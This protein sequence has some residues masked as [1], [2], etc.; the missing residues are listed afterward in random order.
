MDNLRVVISVHVDHEDQLL[1][2]FSEAPH[3][4][5][6][7]FLV[8]EYLFHMCCLQALFEVMLWVKRPP[9]FLNRRLLYG[10]LQGC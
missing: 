3:N 1:A 4:Q 8:R 9:S 7:R 10:G 2:S 6:C 5:C